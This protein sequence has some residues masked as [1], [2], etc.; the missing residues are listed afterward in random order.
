[1]PFFYILPSVRSARDAPVPATAW[2]ADPL[3]I[4]GAN[5]R[6]ERTTRGLTQEQVAD[7][8]RIE[9]S[10]YSRLERA[11]VDPGVRM[12]SR[13]ALGLGVASAQ[14][15]RGVGGRPSA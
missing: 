8:A 2:F 12:V 5:L 13:V 11:V 1:V 10:Y 4:F 15:M 14:L 7:V 3:L 9:A 6:H